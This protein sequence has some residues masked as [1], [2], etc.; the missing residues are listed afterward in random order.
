MAI[1]PRPLNIDL[2]TRITRECQC[3]KI[4]W[5]GWPRDRRF[6]SLAGI[7]D[8]IATCN[9]AG[10]FARDHGFQL[11]IHNHWWEFESVERERPIRLF[12]ELLHP[13]IFWQLDV[14]WAQTAGV[15]PADTLRELESRIKSIHWKDGPAVHGEPMTALGRGNIDVPRILQAVKHP[16][17]W[18]I[19]LDEC[20]TDSLDAAQQSL[21]YLHYSGHQQ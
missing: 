14:Y 9:D 1:Y 7:R 19:E 11:G 18:V 4:V 3:S 8:L 15:D 17:D 2:W 12:H 10:K 16:I 6:E 21:I 20:A 13:D 5:H